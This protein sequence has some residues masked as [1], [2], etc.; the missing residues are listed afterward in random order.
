MK[1]IKRL[2]S[3]QLLSPNNRMKKKERVSLH[4]QQGQGIDGS[5]NPSGTAMTDNNLTQSELSS[6]WNQNHV[7]SSM[8]QNE[9]DSGFKPFLDQDANNQDIDKKDVELFHC[10]T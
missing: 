6:T 5:M 2:L 10:N 3:G 7:R 8:P 4:L 1:K 9:L